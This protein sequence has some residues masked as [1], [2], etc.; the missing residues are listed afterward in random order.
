MARAKPLEFGKRT[1][2]LISGRAFHSVHSRPSGGLVSRASEKGQGNRRHLISECLKQ[3][4]AHRPFQQKDN[5]S[6][7]ELGLIPSEDTHLAAE[8]PRQIIYSIFFNLNCE[9]QLV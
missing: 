6:R 2:V 7:L 4:R 5:C 1:L 9:T 8:L 3:S